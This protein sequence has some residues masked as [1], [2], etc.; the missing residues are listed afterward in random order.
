MTR[1]AVV[2][3]SVR[4][5]RVGQGVAEWVVSKANNVEGVQAELVDIK[6]FDLPLFAEPVPTA[7]S[8][9][10]DPA[11]ARFNET[12][13][14]FDA[15]IIVTPEYNHSIPGA[16]KNALDF[17]EPSALARK[18]VGLVGYSFT[19]GLRP[20]EHLRLILANFQA[21]V[22]NPQV[23]LS[24]VTDFENMSEFKPAAYHDG[25]VEG[26]VA[27]MLAQGNALASLRA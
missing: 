23:S 26:M 8:A 5:N 15:V 17:L 25:E 4:T 14:S 20:V 19:G 13:K 9:P 27:E 12:V 3:G 10:Q 21:A 6:S 24:L 18:G 7:V 11:G 22:V 1:L 16:L 2:L